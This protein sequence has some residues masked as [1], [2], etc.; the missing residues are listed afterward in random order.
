MNRFKSVIKTDISVPMQ[1]NPEQVKVLMVCGPP[2]G[3][4]VVGSYMLHTELKQNLIIDLL[5]CLPNNCMQEKDYLNQRYMRKR[6]I[7]LAY[8]AKCLSDNELISSCAY[9][10]IA[11]DP[12]RPILTIKPNGN[13]KYYLY[14]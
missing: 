7:Y 5:L 13:P 9:S 4:K 14:L 11:N 6:A 3:V 2:S 10:F 8:L 1:F 12:Q